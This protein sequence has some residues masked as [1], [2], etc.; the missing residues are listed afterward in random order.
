[1]EPLYQTREDWLSAA[2]AELRPLFDVIGKPLP[3]RVRVACGFPSNAR[4][5]G[6]I[7]ECWAD[8]ASGDKTFEVLISPVLDNPSRVFDVLVHELCHSTAGAMNHGTAFASVAQAM[9][10]EAVGPASAPWKATVAGVGFVGA[11]QAIIDSLG[12]YPHAALTLNTRKTQSTRMLKAVCPSCGYTIRLT[13]KW[14]AL[15]MPTC[16]VDE[17]LFAIETSTGE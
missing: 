9:H 7:G 15:G 14:A 8:T 10:L 6:A 13:Q 11:Y 4:R 3:Q 12:A 5:S 2:V 17:D 16:P 1:M